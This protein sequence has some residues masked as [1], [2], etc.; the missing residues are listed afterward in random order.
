[1]GQVP[2]LSGLTPPTPI[3]WERQL[4][5][6]GQRL[7][8]AL[9]KESAHKR[10]MKKNERRRVMRRARKRQFESVEKDLDTA[11]VEGRLDPIPLP[12]Q[13]AAEPNWHAM[14]RSGAGGASGS[15]ERDE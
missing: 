4:V 14:L 15:I 13:V 12:P 5:V 7:Q 10:C 11:F 2:P 6:R 9:E 3:H 1:M 8:K